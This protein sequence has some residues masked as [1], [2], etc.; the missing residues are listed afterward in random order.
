M[1][2]LLKK[3]TKIMNSTRRKKITMYQKREFKITE[4]K[5]NSIIYDNLRK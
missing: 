3:N 4:K 1:K 5:K 2:I